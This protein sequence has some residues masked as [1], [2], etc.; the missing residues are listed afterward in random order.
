MVGYT[1]ATDR[2]AILAK[3]EALQNY[4]QEGRNRG[5]DIRRRLTDLE[6]GRAATGDRLTRVEENLKLQT[7]MLREIR[8]ELRKPTARR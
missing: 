4:D 2:T 8:D 7:E 6:S 1:F 3:L 5:D